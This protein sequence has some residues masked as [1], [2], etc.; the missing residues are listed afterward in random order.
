M[1]IHHI[2]T[3]AHGKAQIEVVEPNLTPD[4]SGLRTLTFPAGSAYM[5]EFAGGRKSGLHN[6]PRRQFVV[7]LYGGALVHTPSGYRRDVE[8]GD[9]IFAEDLTGEGHLTDGDNGPRGAIYVTV[10]DDFD[11]QAW[12]AGEETAS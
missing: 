10:P 8:P 7:H 4:K 2:Y 9:I 6:A 3:D 5:K 12:C 11:F 1:K